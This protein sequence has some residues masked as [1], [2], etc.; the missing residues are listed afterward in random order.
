MES[1]IEAIVEN[2]LTNWTNTLHSQIVKVVEFTFE[3][4]SQASYFSSSSGL[5]S[6]MINFVVQALGQVVRSG[7][8]TTASE[9]KICSLVQIKAVADEIV[10]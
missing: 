8:T 7:W 10:K 1:D 2:C 9:A 6:F 4:A 5:Q 3:E